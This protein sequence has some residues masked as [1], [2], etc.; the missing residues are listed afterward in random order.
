MLGKACPCAGTKTAK[1]T[2]N[3]STALAVVLT[4]ALTAAGIICGALAFAN[5]GKP[6]YGIALAVGAWLLAALWRMGHDWDDG[7]DVRQLIFPGPFDWPVKFERFVNFWTD[8]RPYFRAIYLAC[9]A[10]LLVV[11]IVIGGLRPG[12]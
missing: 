5:A 10:A 8:E 9:W 3:A 2:S 12:Q 7:I 1:Q 6:G 11:A 4:F